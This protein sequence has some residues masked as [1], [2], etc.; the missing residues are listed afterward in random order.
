MDLM[1]NIKKNIKKNMRKMEKMKQINMRRNLE[2][3]NGFKTR[4]GRIFKL[5]KLN[6]NIHVKNE[7][8]IHENEAETTKYKKYE[9][10]MS[11]NQLN[12]PN[13]PKIVEK[14]LKIIKIRL[15]QGLKIDNR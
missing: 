9:L 10:K 14:S 2:E 13:K 7:D 12:E 6:F 8:E 1:M 3:K 15:N 4:N 5:I 11:L